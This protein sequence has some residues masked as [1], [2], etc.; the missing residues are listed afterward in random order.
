MSK[1]YDVGFRKPPKH[2]QFQPGLSGNPKGRPKGTK[3]LKTDIK[4]ELAELILIKEGGRPF[5]VS[6]QRAMLKS[7]AAKAIKGDVRAANA[8]FNMIF[9]FD[10]GEENEEPEDL[11]DGKDFEIL[12]EYQRRIVKD[13]LAKEQVNE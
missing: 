9:R 10:S 12:K 6:K 11:F 4:E 13:A 8:L 2:T 5:K 3:N 1:K 7:L